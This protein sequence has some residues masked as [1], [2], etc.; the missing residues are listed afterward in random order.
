MGFFDSLYT[1]APGLDPRMA[2]MLRRQAQLENS[3]RMF[4]GIGDPNAGFGT[5]LAALADSVAG[6]RANSQ[7]ALERQRQLER[8]A[9]QDAMSQR[10]LGIREEDLGLRRRGFEA[11]RG[12]VT[13]SQSLEDADRARR[14]QGIAAQANAAR[15]ILANPAVPDDMRGAWTSRID[16]AE[17]EGDLNELGKIADEIFGFIRPRNPQEQEA[18]QAEQ[19]QTRRSNVRQDADSARADAYLGLA[20]QNAESTRIRA[21]K[22]SG[23]SSAGAL[24]PKQKIDLEND[25]YEQILEGRFTALS[26]P[27]E[28]DRQAARAE[29]RA[30]VEEQAGHYV[31]SST[32]SSGGETR[33]FLLARATR[34][35]VGMGIPPEKLSELARLS[36]DELRDLIADA[37]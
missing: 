28:A 24:T 33:E 25:F 8:Q 14:D 17:Q 27:T 16:A 30:M 7:G 2:Q 1:P 23:S 5:I 18:W 6:Y 19:E 10:E 15:G 11:E 22:P 35:A 37:R 4:S 20:G 21:L 31:A 12:D 3:S 13:R 34:I 26:P 29:A 32:A 9:M 36:D